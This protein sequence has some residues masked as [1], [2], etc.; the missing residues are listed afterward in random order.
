MTNILAIETSCDET[1]IAIIKN[2]CE[3]LSN[4]VSSQIKQHQKYGG[5]VPELASRMHTEIIHTLL[6]SVVDSKEALKNIDAIAVTYGPG[7]EGSLLIGLTL[8]KT[9]AYV[10]KL[11]LIGVNHLIG[12]IY[13]NFLE[14]TPPPFPF[15]CLI[16]SGGHTQLVLVR[17]HLKFELIGTT[18]DDSAGEAFDK[19]AKFLGLAYPGGPEIEKMAIE[20]N[21]L[22]YNLPIA[23]KNEGFDFSFSGLKTACIQ[24]INLMKKENQEINLADFT[25]SFQK[26]VTDTLLLKTK[27]A[28]DYFKIN[29]LA[30]A[31]GVIANSYLR[32]AFQKEFSSPQ[33]NLT[34]PKIK[35]TT[36]NSAMI[37]SAG[38]YYLKNNI[39]ADFNLKVEPNLKIC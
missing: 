20:G 18:R 30:L 14:Q 32:N 22:A 37:G 24:K 5:V 38:Y 35:Y 7:L 27:K 10:L 12:H 17:D 9:L 33:Y 8:A 6:Q 26:T 4:V 15:I 23:L 31:G 16:V 13:A 3:V 39:I 36:D 21:P 11:P 28:L 25:A 19:I 1:S 34:M 2:G 29:N